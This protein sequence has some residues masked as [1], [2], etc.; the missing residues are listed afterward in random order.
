M[1]TGVSSNTRQL[2]SILY[3]SLPNGG[4]STVKD[5]LLIEIIRFSIIRLITTW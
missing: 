3:Q 1:L 4:F 2:E 5:Y